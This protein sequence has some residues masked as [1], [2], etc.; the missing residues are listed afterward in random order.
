MEQRW[1]NSHLLEGSSVPDD[2][3]DGEAEAIPEAED[4]NADN[5]DDDEEEEEEG[6]DDEG[7]VANILA[8]DM[9]R[10][11]FE[12]EAVSISSFLLC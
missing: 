3:S 12:H 10:E 1:G 4:G 6:D 2:D 8:C 5:D 11:C 7:D 9:L